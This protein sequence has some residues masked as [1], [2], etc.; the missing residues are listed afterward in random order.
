MQEINRNGNKRI[1]ADEYKVTHPL[2][3][4]AETVEEMVKDETVLMSR[5]I[6]G[7]ASFAELPKILMS[8]I[9]YIFQ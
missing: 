1:S 2:N 4:S 5:R 7:K 8:R 3:L 9:Q 6:Q